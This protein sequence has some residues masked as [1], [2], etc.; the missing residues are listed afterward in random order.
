MTAV[1]R[2]HHNLRRNEGKGPEAGKG[3]QFP[4]LSGSVPHGEEDTL[5]FSE[6]LISSLVAQSVRSQPVTQET[7]VWSL[8]QEDSPG[9]ENDY[10]L[11]Y[12]YLENSMDRGAWRATV[13]GGTESQTWL[14]GWHTH[15]RTYAHAHTHTHAQAAHTCRFI[16][17]TPVG[18]H[19][20]ENRINDLL[21]IT[22]PTTQGQR[23]IRLRTT[24][25]SCFES[26]FVLR[27]LM[28]LKAVS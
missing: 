18:V 24:C 6:H 16:S 9:E 11:Q 26:E 15:R 8:G 5:N 20:W 13:L 23:R 17:F 21:G 1:E 28:P 4:T 2:S 27:V 19:V 3:F 7:W 25:F 12:S 10:P 22:Q 14:S